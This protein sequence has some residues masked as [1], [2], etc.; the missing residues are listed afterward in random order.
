M[1]APKVISPLSGKVNKSGAMRDQSGV[2]SLSAD[3]STWTLTTAPHR[4]EM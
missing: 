2:P 3:S 4:P 1:S